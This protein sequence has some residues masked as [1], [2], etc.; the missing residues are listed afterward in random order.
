MLSS[1]IGMDCL[2]IGKEMVHIWNA[3]SNRFN[4]CDGR[5]RFAAVLDYYCRINWFDLKPAEI[6]Q[7][8]WPTTEHNLGVE[9]FTSLPSVCHVRLFPKIHLNPQLPFT[10]IYK[11]MLGWSWNHVKS[12]HFVKAI[13]LNTPSWSGGYGTDFRDFEPFEPPF[14]APAPPRSLW[15]AGGCNFFWRT[16]TNRFY[17]ENWDKSTP[18]SI[19]IHT[20]VN[21]SVAKFKFLCNIA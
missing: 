7:Y 16:L 10:N 13:P 2:E 14:A 6:Y 8:I 3:S 4:P 11:A 18:S 15:K 21:S 1:K 19:H 12:H 5:N 17:S 20:V 9:T